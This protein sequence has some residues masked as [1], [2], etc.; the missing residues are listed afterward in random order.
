MKKKNS[1]K[2]KYILAAKHTWGESKEDVLDDVLELKKGIKKGAEGSLNLD[3][4]QEDF[5][6]D[7]VKYMKRCDDKNK[8]LKSKKTK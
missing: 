4:T 1:N 6:A 8:N 7:I 5:R 3:F 2:E